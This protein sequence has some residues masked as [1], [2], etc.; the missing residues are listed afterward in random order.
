MDLMSVASTGARRAAACLRYLP[1]L[2]MGRRRPLVRGAIAAIG[3][4]SGMHEAAQRIL[5]SL[6]GRR[7]AVAVVHGPTP[8]ACDAAGQMVRALASAGLLPMRIGI[9]QAGQLGDDNRQAWL[10]SRCAAICLVGSSAEA[11]A[12]VLINPVDT[13]DLPALRAIRGALGRGC[14]L[15]GAGSAAGVLSKTIICSG[16]STHSLLGGVGR[17]SLGKGLGLLPGVVIDHQGLRQGHIGRLAVAVK[18]VG[19]AFGIS[20]EDSA[21]VVFT[22]HR[23]QVVGRGQIAVLEYDPAQTEHAW[24]LSILSAGDVIAPLDGKITLGSMSRTEARAVDMLAPFAAVHGNVFGPGALQELIDNMVSQRSQHAIGFALPQE[25]APHQPLRAVGLRLCATARTEVLE[26]SLPVPQVAAVKRLGLRFDHDEAAR[27][28]GE[29]M[30][31][32]ANFAPRLQRGTSYL[33]YDIGLEQVVSYRCSSRAHVPGAMTQLVAAALICDRLEKL[34]VDIAVSAATTDQTLTASAPPVF[35]QGH[36]SGVKLFQPC[37]DVPVV[38]LLRALLI[39]SSQDAALALARWHSGTTE[40]FCVAMNRWSANAGMTQSHFSCPSG[41][42]VRDRTTIADI[43]KLTLRIG[44]RYACIS[45]IAREPAF[46]WRDRTVTNAHPLLGWFS[47][48]TGLKAANAGNDE[49]GIICTAHTHERRM[50]SIVLGAAGLSEAAGLAR[51]LL[52]RELLG[53]L[54]TPRRA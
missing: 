42:D 32:I 20:L 26:R 43:L 23:W 36:G 9:T 47:P 39:T 27:W 40:E 31:S 2:L 14:V 37:E 51:S 50:V 35:V 33:L 19:Y 6:C 3:D 29:R 30:R 28:L 52:E 49:A 5:K 54:A 46:S 1:A 22:L 17:V 25:M 48:I 11:L 34:G 15:V 8:Q 13:C 38:Q 16:T 10:V 4:G 45:R 21:A 12:E 7:G 53:A 44:A 24:H 41:R 18:H